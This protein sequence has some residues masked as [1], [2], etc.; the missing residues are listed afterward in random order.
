[1]YGRSSSGTKKWFGPVELG[2]RVRLGEEHGHVR[3][4]DLVGRVGV[5]VDVPGRDVDGA[6]GGVGHTVHDDAGAAACASA[7]TAA[8]STISPS[9]FETCGK[10][11][12]RVRSESTASSVLEGRRAR[13]GVDLP[14]ADPGALLL[15]PEPGSDVR[16]VPASAIDDLVAGSEDRRVGVREHP[17]EDGGRGAED[18]LAD[19]VAVHQ[20]VHEGVRIVRRPPCSV[21][22]RA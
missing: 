18:D 4:V 10:A 3:P 5:V 21:G 7:V 2:E 17:A 15:E 6:V 16:L 13:L 8:T 11:T 1:M 20:G 19:A 14:G 12:M 9:R 22:E